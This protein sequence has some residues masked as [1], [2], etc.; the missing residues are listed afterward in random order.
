MTSDREL[1]WLAK[2][3][4]RTCPSCGHEIERVY[5]R[6]CC[7]HAKPCEHRLAGKGYDWLLD[8]LND[9]TEQE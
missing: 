1:E 9:P 3:E 4:A 2:I 8:L 6:S 7:I 5:K